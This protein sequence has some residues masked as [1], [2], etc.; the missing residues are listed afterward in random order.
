MKELLRSN[1][2]VLISWVEALLSDSRI[3]AVVLDGCSRWA[4]FSLFL[5]VS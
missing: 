3:G 2:P 4:G 5:G 1:D